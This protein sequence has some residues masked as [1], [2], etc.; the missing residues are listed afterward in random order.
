VVKLIQEAVVSRL[1]FCREQTFFDNLPFKEIPEFK[2][3]ML[4]RNYRKFFPPE[5][6]DEICPKP[7]DEVLK[8]A[9]RADEKERKEGEVLLETFHYQ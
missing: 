8:L 6:Q 3:V 7:S 9:R 1:S 4:Y 2:Q 5:H